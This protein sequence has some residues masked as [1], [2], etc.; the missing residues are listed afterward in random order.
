MSR[1]VRKDTRQLE[2]TI[3]LSIHLVSVYL[4]CSNISLPNIGWQ[5]TG[6]QG[7]GAA[8]SRVYKLQVIREDEA[9][10]PHVD[11]Y[12][13]NGRWSLSFLYV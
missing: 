5:S 6:S 3:L 1:K 10:G 13:E 2:F 9:M 8:E 4:Y 11:V 12:R 7:K